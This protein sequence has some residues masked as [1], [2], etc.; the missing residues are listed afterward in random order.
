MKSYLAYI[1]MTL[2]L[3]L[4]DRLV[5]FF[6]YLFPLVL[7]FAFGER[8][9]GSEGPGA[10]VQLIAMLLILSVLGSGLFGG[11]MRAV[12]EREANILR[13]FKVA[14]ISPSPILVSSIVVGWLIWIPSVL[15]FMAIAHYRYGFRVPSHPLSLLLFLTLGVVA[16][17][18]F[19]LIIASVVNSM[20]ESQIIIQLLYLPML[21]LSGATIPLILFPVWLQVLSQ[22]I[23]S[24]HLYL[25]MQGILMRDESLWQN[26]APALALMITAVVAFFIS[27]KLFR[28]EKGE[29]IKPAN[30]LWLLAVLAPFFLIG[31]WQA[32][33]KGNL[34][35][36]RI[37]ARDL[38]RGR[39]LL[40]RDARIVVGD[41]RVIDSGAV[42]IRQGRIEEVYEGKSPDAASVHAEAV[43]ASGKT[44]LPGLID[45]SVQLGLSGGVTDSGA[46]DLDAKGVERA[47]KSY[48][49]CGVTGVRDSGKVPMQL[50]GPLKGQLESGE[51]LGAELFFA[52]QGQ[53]AALP[54]FALA[55]ALDQLSSGKATGFARSL[56][57]Q[58]G[59]MPLLES[60]NKKLA[61]GSLNVLPAALDAERGRLEESRRA[62]LQAVAAGIP[63]V[64]GTESGSLLL[65]HGP[66]LL[67]EVQLAVAAG[68]PAKTALQA[69]TGN[70]ARML[71]AE[72]RIGL[73]RK[74]QQA[75]LLIVE[76]NPLEEIANLDR[77]FA[78]L[79][80]GEQLDR[81]ELFEE[82]K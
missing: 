29:K 27:M 61:D 65:M 8:L 43:E 70:A 63:V 51:K 42:L 68:V 54:H 80:R 17:R 1:R 18:G 47:L 46:R 15:V 3:A 28:W 60:T 67:R 11:G 53:A 35:R 76:G 39:S 31:A 5:L 6:N 40:I 49:F 44:V 73:I 14:P 2:R 72:Q 48:L 16:F 50:A 77:I 56:V 34:T 38:R 81:A 78:V 69:A 12:M 75:T 74:G 24:T 57:Q 58:V 23:P 7:F 36:T 59:P 62:F 33:T 32:H 26:L 19:G 71:H 45:F 9:R 37:L 13:R 55:E 25:G 41:G 64:F 22:F 20:A 82:T 79:F 21:L 52:S 4:R 30:K 66:A 10:A